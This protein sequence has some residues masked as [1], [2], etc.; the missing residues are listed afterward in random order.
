MPSLHHHRL[1]NRLPLLRRIL[2]G[3]REIRETI[4]N[5]K[6]EEIKKEV[7]IEVLEKEVKTVAQGKEMNTMRRGKE[8][9]P[10]TPIDVTIMINTTDSKAEEH[11]TENKA[12]E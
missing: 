1:R 11:K 5:K 12:E 9:K 3:D 2:A 7:K 4:I 10:K 6:I 8:V